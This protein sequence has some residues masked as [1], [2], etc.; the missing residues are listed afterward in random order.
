MCVL[1]RRGWYPLTHMGVRVLPP[2]PRKDR[3]QCLCSDPDGD[4]GALAGAALCKD[5]ISLKFYI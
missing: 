1:G 5:R 2:M 4:L 3:G